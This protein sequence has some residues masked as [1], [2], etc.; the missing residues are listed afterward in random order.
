MQ[1]SGGR[2]DLCNYEYANIRTAVLADAFQPLRDL[3]RDHLVQF[4]D[5]IYFR[6]ALVVEACPLGVVTRSRQSPMVL[7]RV[8]RECSEPGPACCGKLSLGSV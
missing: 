8:D 6:H 3:V 1:S 5:T 2:T 7:C 4:F